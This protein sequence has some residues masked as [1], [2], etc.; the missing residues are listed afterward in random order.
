MQ[1]SDA[2]VSFCGNNAVCR[3]HIALCTCGACTQLQGQLGG[4][5]PSQRQARQ[6][7][8]RRSQAKSMV[9][10]DKIL[11]TAARLC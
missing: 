2:D 3:L 5:D 9:Q 6:A 8:R 11:E 7:A 4:N 1:E 10:G